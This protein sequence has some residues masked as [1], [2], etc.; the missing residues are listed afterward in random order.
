VIDEFAAM[1]NVRRANDPQA[2][3]LSEEQAL[4]LRSNL[5]SM[6]LS[7]QLSLLTRQS[8]IWR[9]ELSEV[10]ALLNTRFDVEAT[11]TKAA[12]RLA[13]ELLATPISVKLPTLIDSLSA[14]ES[15]DRSVSTPAAPK[16]N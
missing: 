12:L 10:E 7:A 5:R 11:N 2:L 8:D 1:V 15:L 13:Q 4:A 16:V 14:L 3:L 9:S 6:L